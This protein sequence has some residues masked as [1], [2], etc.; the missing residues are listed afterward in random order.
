VEHLKRQMRQMKLR[1]SHL[2]RRMHH[3]KLGMTTAESVQRTMT[4]SNFNPA[5]QLPYMLEQSLW[6][7]AE[8]GV[9]PLPEPRGHLVMFQYIAAYATNDDDCRML[10]QTRTGKV[11]LYRFNDPNPTVLKQ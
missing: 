6:A 8:M 2:Q 3:S 4:R 5:V 10:L 7:E 9:P 1:L 11:L